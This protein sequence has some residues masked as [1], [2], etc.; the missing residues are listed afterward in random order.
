MKKSMTNLWAFNEPSAMTA[1]LKQNVA[2]RLITDSRV[3]KAGDCFIAWPG[4]KTDGRQYVQAAF[5][6]G[7]RICVVEQEGS[8]SY[9][10][11]DTRIGMYQGLKTD[12]GWI[13]DAYFDHPSK[14]MDVFAV[15]GTNGKTTTAWLLSQAIANATSFPCGIVGTLGI[16]LAMPGEI[17]SVVHNGL[18]TPDPVL[19]QESFASMRKANAK[20]CVLEAS[21]IGIAEGRLN[22]TNIRVAIFTNFTQDHLDYHSSMQAYWESKLQLFKW[23]GLESVVVNIDDVKG[24]ELADFAEK[25]DL[26]VWTVSATQVAKIYAEK[27]EYAHD[28]MVFDLVEG[29]SRHRLQTHLIGKYNVINLL[30]VVAALRIMGVPLKKTIDVCIKFVPVPGRMEQI[31]LGTDPLVIVDYAHTPDALMHVLKALR[32]LVEAR[33]GA[34]WVVFGCGGN[35]DTSKR[36][37]MGRAAQNFADHI[38]VT[39]DNPRNEEPENIADEILQGIEE[40]SKVTVQ[41][42]RAKAIA[43]ALSQASTLDVIVVAGKGHEQY[44]EIRE[45]RWPFSDA[46][47]INRM[48]QKKENTP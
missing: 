42:D 35:R 39:N 8:A 44:Q 16:G 41:L 18:T 31:K 48:L 24:V 21:S 7:A 46:E 23:S 26:D 29:E 11:T 47:Q 34:L 15:T 28:G 33:H 36:P 17:P 13:A 22:G 6:S 38:V 3:V 14:S 45:T 30:G 25:K 32:P 12:A 37:L 5:D 2:G 20:S 40:K 43:F 19:L 4:A 27:I 9:E 1:W 10:F